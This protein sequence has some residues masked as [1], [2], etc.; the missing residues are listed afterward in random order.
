MCIPTASSQSASSSPPGW[1]TPP[2]PPTAICSTLSSTPPS[3]AISKTEPSA[4][5]AQSLLKNPA[6]TA[7]HS[8]PA[9]ATPASA[10]A[11]AQP[12]C[13]PAPASTKPGP[14]ARNSAKPSSNSSAPDKPFTKEN[15]AA[16]YETRRRASWVERGAHEA[17]NARNGFHG[18]IVKGMIGMALAGLT[19]G[20]L[21]LQAHIPPAHRQIS[22]SGKASS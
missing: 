22:R 8:S 19:G 18:G 6:V 10:R 20:R 16:T 13:S 1:A 9:T 7:S 2:A 11:P 4:P 12:T 3:G 17:E 14:P 21:S 15:L 5:G